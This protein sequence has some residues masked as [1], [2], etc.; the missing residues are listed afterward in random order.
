M[1][2]EIPWSGKRKGNEKDGRPSEAS[3]AEGGTKSRAELESEFRDLM[4]KGMYEETK[5]DAGKGIIEGDGETYSPEE[6]A[7]FL[8]AC[9]QDLSEFA[10]GIPDLGAGRA[11][12]ARYGTNVGLFVEWDS[13]GVRPVWVR[14]AADERSGSADEER[15]PIVIAK[16]L[17]FPVL[18]G[19]FDNAKTELERLK[20]ESIRKGLSSESS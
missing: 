9:S 20:A 12:N 16:Q 14:H 18:E 11:G 2:F 8:G 4:R 5:A 1:L 17:P 15:D 10:A 13:D 19:A 3:S 7:G 6:K